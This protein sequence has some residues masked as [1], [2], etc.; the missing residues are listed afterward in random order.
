[1]E[2]GQAFI[3]YVLRIHSKS[4][5]LSRVV[6]GDDS[7]SFPKRRGPITSDAQFS[8]FRTLWGSSN[9]QVMLELLVLPSNISLYTPEEI[10][11]VF[12]IE[13]PANFHFHWHSHILWWEG[14]LDTFWQFVIT[15]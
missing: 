10:I 9:R 3:Q 1:M 14:K 13:S 12:P 5:T 4:R 7:V 6:N 2:Q 11:S 8:L 15:Y